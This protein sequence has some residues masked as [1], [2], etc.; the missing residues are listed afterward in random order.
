MRLGRILSALCFILCAVLGAYCCVDIIIAT[1]EPWNEELRANRAFLAVMYFIISCMM[2][3]IYLSMDTDDYLKK[4]VLGNFPNR[5][6]ATSC[7]C[8]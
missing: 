6:K 4:S 2:Y 7:T 3:I 1:N 5:K 8:R